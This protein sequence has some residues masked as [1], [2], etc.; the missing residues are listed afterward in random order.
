MGRLT[1]HSAYD[2]LEQ[3]LEDFR[4]DT[5]NGWAV[6]LEEY[7]GRCPKVRIGGTYLRPLGVFTLPLSRTWP[8]LPFPHMDQ[9]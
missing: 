7:L 4:D 1:Y 2:D 5:V 9:C 8:T 6:M 3:C